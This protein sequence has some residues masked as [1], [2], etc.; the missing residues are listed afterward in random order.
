MLT[1]IEKLLETKTTGKKSHVFFTQWQMAKDYVPQVL[2]TI[3]QVF[4]HYSLHDRTH[5]E[6]IIYII[7]RIVGLKTLEKMSSIDLWMILCAA[8]YHD[9]G[10][11][12]YSNEEIDFFQ[13]EKFIEFL[14]TI[15]STESSSL[16]DYSMCF[17]IKDNK[18]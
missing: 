17:D 18:V 7:G 10:M 1:E 6:T 9:V 14:K 5:S 8:Y 4:P 12:V 15:Q 13:D 3:S 2:N 16:H 11:A